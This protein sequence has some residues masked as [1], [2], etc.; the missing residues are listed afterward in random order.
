M[1]GRENRSGNVKIQYIDKETNKLKT[2]TEWRNSV[3]DSKAQNKARQLVRRFNG[4]LFVKKYPMYKCTLDEL[5]RYM[6][7]LEKFESFVPDILICD[8]PDIMMPPDPNAATRDNLNKMYMV[9]KRWADERKMLVVVASQARRD[10]IR[11]KRFSQKDFAE[12]IRKLGNCDTSIGVCQTDNQSTAGL[13][14]LY[15]IGARKGK[16][17]WGCGIVQNLDIGAFASDSF[18]LKLGVKV[19]EEEKESYL[20]NDAQKT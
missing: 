3:A 7:Y 16:D 5:E 8:Y 12:D 18:P 11:A 15:V 17:N 2:M 6:D 4:E 1:L 9:H 13:A 14:S 19:A 10:A 20:N